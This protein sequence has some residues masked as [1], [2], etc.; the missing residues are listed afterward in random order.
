MTALSGHKLSFSYNGQKPVLADLDFHTSSGRILG[1]AGANGSGKSTLINILAGIYRPASGEL[2]LDEL[3]GTAAWNEL[4]LASALMP[5]NV[6]HWLLGENGREDLALGLDPADPATRLRLDEIIGRW[7]LETFIDS[8]V[9]TLSLGQKKRL[10]MAAALARRPRAVFLDEPFAGLDWP[11]VRA[12]LSDLARLKEE[13][14]IVV[15]VTHEPGLVRDLVD[16]WLLLK[17]GG[18]YLFGQ[19]LSSSFESFGVRPF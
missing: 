14:I 4:R 16:D 12:M 1:L 5:Q 18:E 19:D 11:G 15:M 7:Q 6:D 8:P 2:R 13:G 9:E 3:S 10:A 17:S